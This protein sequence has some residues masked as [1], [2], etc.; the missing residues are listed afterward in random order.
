MARLQKKKNNDIQY[1]LYRNATD[2]PLPLMK[3]TDATP[4]SF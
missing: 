3:D 1:P 4:T 2:L